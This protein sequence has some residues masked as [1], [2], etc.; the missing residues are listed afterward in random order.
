MKL[1]VLAGLR[2]LQPAACSR[3]GGTSPEIEE[4]C[5]G[6]D[7]LN[8]RTIFLSGDLSLA[9]DTECRVEKIR[10]LTIQGNS[11]NLATIQCQREAGNITSSLFS[12]V[13]VTSLTLTS[14]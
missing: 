1:L 11:S 2:L 7:G 5:T 12:F 10:N 9:P 4:I 6:G 3:W 14:H 13:N 8:H